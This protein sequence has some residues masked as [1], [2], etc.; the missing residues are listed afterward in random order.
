VAVAAIALAYLPS[1]EGP[2]LSDDHSYLGS[3]NALRQ[4]PLSEFWRFFTTRTNPL[5]FLPLRDLSYRIDLA[6]FGSETL[7]FHLHNLL[8]YLLGCF[9]LW[10]LSYRV[11]QLTSSRGTPPTNPPGRSRMAWIAT[12]TVALFAAHPAHVESVAW[13]AGRKELLSGLFAIGSLWLFVSAIRGE[14]IDTVR[15]LASALLF[16]CALLSKSTA[17][18]LPG[19]ALVLA[20]RRSVELRDRIDLRFVLRAS[21]PL[22]LVA[23]GGLA[24]HILVGGETGVL[25]AEKAALAKS[26]TLP[27][28]VLGYLVRIA[29][30]PVHLRLFYDVFEPSLPWM[31]AA[32]LAVALLLATVFALRSYLRQGSLPALGI[33]IFTIFC[34]PFLQLIPFKT[35]SFA[36]ER[37]LF[38]PVLGM[39]LACSTFLMRRERAGQV[40]LV[41]LFAL[42]LAGTVSRASEWRSKETLLAKNVRHTPHL[43]LPATMY[44]YQVLLPDRRY[45]AAKKVARGIRSRTHSDT[46]LAFVETREALDAGAHGEAARAAARMLTFLAPFTPSFKVR[47]ANMAL[48]AGLVAQV[49]PVYDALLA[50]FPSSVMI[51][52][53]RGLAL[54]RSGKLVEAERSIQRSL[55]NGCTQADAWNNLGLI[56]R[57][58]GKRQAAIAAFNGALAAEAKHWHAAFNLARLYLT[59]EELDR[60]RA[61]LQEARKRAIS[62]GDNPQ[63]IDRLLHQIDTT[64]AG[65]NVPG[66]N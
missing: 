36:S 41:L 46:I 13:V 27:I 47:A 40:A 60:A 59:M 31:T 33:V 3:N 14:R 56:R 57:D 65:R 24:L 37:F 25:G 53:N 22:L 21:G 42:L 44:I 18:P 64:G 50:E 38:L 29:L 58:L 26:W 49:L 54:K 7:G 35:W 12:V 34:L 19:V 1:L 32:L 11:V 5:E 15:Q 20:L 30:F 17:L 43:S 16:G 10:G 62:A 28:R 8:L 61:S 52:Y 39:S 9:A 48:E 51:P 4:I 45:E 6:L 55:A 23:G 66:A 2:W 63:L